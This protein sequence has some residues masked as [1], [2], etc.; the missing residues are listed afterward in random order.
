VPY[1]VYKLV[2]PRTDIPHYVGVTDNLTRRRWEH[3]NNVGVTNTLKDAWIQELVRKGLEP[4]IEVIETAEEWDE[5]LEREKYWIQYYIR[6]GV[7]L[8][9]ITGNPQRRNR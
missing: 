7:H 4:R 5:V 2:D 3:L 8:F 1:Y 6:Q 9:N